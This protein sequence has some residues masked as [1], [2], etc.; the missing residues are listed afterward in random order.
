MRYREPDLDGM[1][2]L[3]RLTLNSNIAIGDDGLIILVEV[4]QDDLWMKAVDL[5]NCG[6]TDIGADKINNLLAF[7]GVID[8]V[9]IRR[10]PDVSHSTMQNVMMMLC[11][12]CPMD[13]ADKQFQ[14][15]NTTTTLNSCSIANSISQAGLNGSGTS[16]QLYLNLSDHASKGSTAKSQTENGLKRSNTTFALARRASD[17]ATGVRWVI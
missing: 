14:W 5:Q 2:G 17:T 9:D 15:L 13:N 10:N 16:H 3:R 8:I 4:L 6:I 11:K 12:N 7:N 1:R